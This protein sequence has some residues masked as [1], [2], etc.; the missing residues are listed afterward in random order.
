CVADAIPNATIRWW[1][2]GQDLALQTNLYQIE[3]NSAGESRLHVHPRAGSAQRD[4]FG[5]YR[6]EAFNSL[7]ANDVI[8]QLEEAFRPGAIMQTLHETITPTTIT[9]RLMAPSF[10]GGLPVTKIRAQY[11]E[12]RESEVERREWPLD[13][14]SEL[15]FVDRLFP[16]TRYLFRFAAENIVGIGL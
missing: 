3:P 1:F 16:N 12:E 8:I 11:R 15:Y 10:D 13:R 14:H 7:G 4:I 6:C 2:R 9:F 5:A